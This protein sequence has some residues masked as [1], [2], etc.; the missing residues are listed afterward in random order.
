MREPGPELQ[1]RGGSPSR[2]DAA[3]LAAFAYDLVARPPPAD[4]AVA[5]PPQGA[6]GDIKG[7]EAPSPW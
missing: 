5:E 6:A 2:G 7:R 3:A 4:A 1:L